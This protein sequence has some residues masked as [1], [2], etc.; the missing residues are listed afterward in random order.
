LF[1][2][3][4]AVSYFFIYRKSLIIAN[5]QEYIINVIQNVCKFIV[6]A[7]Q[8][9]CFILLR[10]FYV[11]LLIQIGATIA[12]NLFISYICK[13]KFPHLSESAEPL[14]KE[15]RRG[16]FK[17]VRALMAHKISNSIT[18]GTESIFISSFVGIVAVGLYSNYLLVVTTIYATIKQIVQS[19]TASIGNLNA[20]ASVAKQ[21]LVYK[22]VNFMSFWLYGMTGACMY[23]LFNTLI[24]VWIGEENLFAKYLVAIIAVNFYAH[25]ITNTYYTFRTTYGLFVQGQLRPIFS[26]VIHIISSLV[27]AQFIGM[28]GIFIGTFISYTAIYVWFDPL[29]VHRHVFKKSPFPFYLRSAVYFLT[30]VGSAYLVSQVSGLISISN[31]WLE[32]ICKGLICFALVNVIFLVLFFK[33]KEF[34]YIYGNVM[35]LLKR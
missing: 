5:Q 15:E 22:S 13:R 34:K 21:E 35:S 30:F 17:D 27:L 12:Q 24:T 3:N 29:V 26:A 2:A 9:A 31:P 1:L 19:L 28:A 25:G 6:A 4:S 33:T 10:D 18:L 8:I 14:P 16:I 11:Y 20:T 23:A 7:V 32:L